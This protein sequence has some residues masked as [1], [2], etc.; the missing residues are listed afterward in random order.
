M[1]N[2]YQLS[3]YSYLSNFPNLL[4]S[5]IPHA[6]HESFPS[7]PAKFP[8]ILLFLSFLSFHCIFLD[9]I[10]YILSPLTQQSCSSLLGSNNSPDTLYVPLSPKCSCLSLCWRICTDLKANS[11]L[12]PWYSYLWAFWIRS[13]SSAGSWK[14]IF[15]MWIPTF[16]DF[17]NRVEGD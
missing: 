12:T 13:T 7:N 4:G 10:L 5:A 14:R 16:A 8:P 2:Y 9:R 1:V 3:K 17:G 6:F 15:G 11:F